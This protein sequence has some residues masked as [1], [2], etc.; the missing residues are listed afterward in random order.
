MTYKK[1][2]YMY[3]EYVFKGYYYR[4]LIS[5]DQFYEIQKMEGGAWYN[6]AAY[7][8]KDRYG[9]SMHTMTSDQRNEETEPSKEYL[10][11]IGKGLKDLYDLNDEQIQ[12]YLRT[13]YQL[14][15][16][17]EHVRKVMERDC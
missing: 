7:L 16:S 17:E 8:G 3:K 9:V 14:D 11:V 1:C 4:Y 15:L 10:E 6:N 5:Y 2:A 12:D 13:S